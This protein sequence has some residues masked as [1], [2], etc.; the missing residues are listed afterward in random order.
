MSKLEN[1]NS[2]GLDKSHKNTQASA[3]TLIEL[4][5]VIAI[6][7]VI[8]AILFP[9]L[10]AASRRTKTI[11]CMNNLKN[12]GMSWFIYANDNKGFLPPVYQPTQYAEDG[13]TVIS[14]GGTWAFILTNLQLV[15]P[16]WDDANFKS[17]YCPSWA[18]ASPTDPGG[19]A[20]WTF[21]YGAIMYYDWL[22]EVRRLSD[23]DAMTPIL[24]DSISESSGYPNYY[25][26]IHQAN[27]VSKIHLR[28]NGKANLFF[29][30]GHGESADA[31]R[32]QQLE[33][34]GAP[35]TTWSTLPPPE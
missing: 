23:Y 10:G 11:R 3:F 6:L 29:A 9:A 21:I 12:L 31:A 7:A 27:P 25:I 1:R 34:K 30:D 16:V 17:W 2:L 18:P 28:H 15:P 19:G 8:L 13:K 22:D 32:L 4:L 5:T 20:P 24:A 14:D 33:F 26:P 35:I